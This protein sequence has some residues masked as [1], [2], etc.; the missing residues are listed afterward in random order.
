MTAKV[1]AEDRAAG[2]GCWSGPVNP[3]PIAGGL[4]N[5]N[6]VVHDRGERY[7]VRVG[8]DLPIHGILRFNEAAVAR[9][10]AAAGVSP[11]VIH[12]E[13][14]AIVIR[15]IDGHTLT[16]EDV[17]VPV[18]LE[19]IVAL[20]H[21]AHTDIPAYLRGP[22]LMFWVFHVIRD[23]VSGLREH[24]GD[25]ASS[26]EGFLS[27]AEVLEQAVGPIDVV[28]GHNDLLAANLI[29]DGERLWLI[30]WDYAGF[31]SPLFDLGGLASNS[32]L[33]PDQEAWLL[34]AYYGRAPDPDLRRQ[35]EAMKCASLLRETL[36]SM[37]SA[38]HSTI[39]EDFDAYTA[40]NLERF[41][42]AY[43]AF[44][45]TSGTTT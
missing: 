44:V 27:K 43:D 6:F 4:T 22:V 11:E 18:M 38:I 1:D 2:L 40:K 25:A 19:R 12:S 13:P 10:A 24:G 30:D 36:W 21:S 41:E 42:L 28:L 35:F 26:L 23:Y 5:T 9:A 20:V 15:F 16:P 45:G 33:S 7:F 3:E 17:R 14:G 32:E 39:D 29:D 31:N 34:E 37:T 8:H